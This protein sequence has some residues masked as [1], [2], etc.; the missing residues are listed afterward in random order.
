MKALLDDH[1]KIEASGDQL[2]EI[3]LECILSKAR[4]SLEHLK[5][6]VEI[7][8]EIFYPFYL[9]NGSAQV[10]AVAT[11]ARVWVNNRNR[12]LNIVEKLY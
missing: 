6:F 7:Y 8:S 1:T 4:K 9:N 11:V 3:F 10:T 2:K 5:R 12:A